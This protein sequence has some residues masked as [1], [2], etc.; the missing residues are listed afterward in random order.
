MKKLAFCLILITLFIS[1]IP[2]Q[3]NA[4]TAG[5][6]RRQIEDTNNQI[7]QLDKEIQRYQSQIAET[8]EQANSLAKIIKELTLTRSK[9]VKEKQQIEKKIKATG[10][11]IE[12]LSY[13]IKDKEESINLA[14][15]TLREMIKDLNQNED[16]L[17][18]ERLLS[19]NSFIDFSREYNDIL[20]LNE[21]IK[22]RINKINTE[23]QEL[24]SSKSQKENE[25]Q[26]SIP[27]I[28]R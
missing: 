12:T 10:L 6:V 25:K 3:V 24:L 22:E 11:V 21:K 15:E 9:L 2:S 8:S 19:E 5:E 28:E 16:I 18:V 1:I 20:S 14:K 7:E 17:F 4:L 27:I 26:R 23:K 13:D